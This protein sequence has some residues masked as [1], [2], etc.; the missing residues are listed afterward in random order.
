MA[1][2][3]GYP[4][5]PPFAQEP[6]QQYL[7]NAHRMVAA[8]RKTEERGY[9]IPGH[10]GPIYATDIFQTHSKNIRTW[11]RR[12]DGRIFILWQD[13]SSAGRMVNVPCR[14]CAYINI[15]SLSRE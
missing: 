11:Y 6:R 1:R 7:C 12:A 9:M 14:E 10:N 5:E 15:S 8:L 2:E 3:S 13:E 4:A